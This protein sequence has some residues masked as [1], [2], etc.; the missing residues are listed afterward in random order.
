MQFLFHSDLTQ[1]RITQI[2]LKTKRSIIN[3]YDKMQKE[4]VQ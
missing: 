1:I 3:D 2:Q 4:A